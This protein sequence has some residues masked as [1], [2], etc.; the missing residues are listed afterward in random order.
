MVLVSPKVLRTPYYTSR[1]ASDTQA[2][3][4]DLAL[5]TIKVDFDVVGLKH[6]ISARPSG[7]TALIHIGDLSNTLGLDGF[8]QSFCLEPCI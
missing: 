6:P 8:L 7:L 4:I 3:I 2:Y 5:L 1:Y